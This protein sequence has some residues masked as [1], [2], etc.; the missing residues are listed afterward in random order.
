MITPITSVFIWFVAYAVPLGA[1][2]III[3]LWKQ[4]K[5]WYERGIGVIHT[6]LLVSIAISQYAIYT[7]GLIFPWYPGFLSILVFTA[8]ILFALSIIGA[9]GFLYA[10]SVFIQEL[11]LLSLAFLLLPIF[12][13]WMVVLLIVPLFV[14]CHFLSLEYWKLK[15]ALVSLWGVMSILLFMI[16][17]NIF[18][19][20]SLHTILGAILTFRQ[21]FL[22]PFRPNR[23]T[24]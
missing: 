19:V 9:F 14:A 11:A 13:V 18:L 5:F 23:G 22:N 2:G 16:T 20:A 6:A 3:Y 10:V 12:P 15:L 21:I 1:A 24:K 8:S 4:K 7:S 17:R